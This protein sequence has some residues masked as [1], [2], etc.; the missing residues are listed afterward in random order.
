MYLKEHRAVLFRIGRLNMIWC[1]GVSA[2]WGA[3][4]GA[5]PWFHLKTASQAAATGTE[6]LRL[7]EPR[8]L[9]D[10]LRKRSSAAQALN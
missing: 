10:A 8:I 6:L 9:Q 4:D 3:H 2:A 1:T 5:F 7:F